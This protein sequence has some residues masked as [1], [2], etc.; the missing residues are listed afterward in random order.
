[1]DCIHDGCLKTG[2]HFLTEI[3]L[4]MVP[5]LVCKH[6]SNSQQCGGVI[7]RSEAWRPPFWA[8]LASAGTLQQWRTRKICQHQRAEAV[9]ESPGWQ[10]LPRTSAAK[11]EGL[12]YTETLPTGMRGPQ[13]SVAGGPCVKGT[14]PCTRRYCRPFTNRFSCLSSA[15]APLW[16]PSGKS[17]A[18]LEGVNATSRKLWL[19]ANARRLIPERPQRQSAPVGDVLTAATRG[20]VLPALLPKP[21]RARGMK[22]VFSL[23]FNEQAA[24]EVPSFLGKLQASA[25]GNSF[26]IL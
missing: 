23:P 21:A 20:R 10:G 8:P 6:L 26:F 5:G 24:P 1:M 4:E 11:G 2:I 25:K 19:T 9:G 7:L 3:V 22:P 16:S 18:R 12:S 13:G 15:Q 17:S 14:L